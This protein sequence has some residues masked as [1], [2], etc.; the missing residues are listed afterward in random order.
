VLHPG[1]ARV[2]PL[3]G[4]SLAPRASVLGPSGSARG[5]VEPPTPTNPL[6]AARARPARRRRCLPAPS[7][8]TALLHAWY[9][10]HAS[11]RA[12][13]LAL[14]SA[15]AGFPLICHTPPVAVQLPVATATCR[16]DVDTQRAVTMA[17]IAPVPL[18]GPRLPLRV[19]A[20][21]PWTGVRV[22]AAAAAGSTPVHGP[23]P[24]WRTAP[25]SSPPCCQHS[26]ES[27]PP[28]Y[29]AGWVPERVCNWFLCRFWR[30]QLWGR[31]WNGWVPRPPVPLYVGGYVLLVWRC[32]QFLLLTSTCVQQIADS[33][34]CVLLSLSL[35]SIFVPAC[36]RVTL[37][38]SLY[39][40]CLLL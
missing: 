17:F 33:V 38:P 19:T 20:S 15:D 22:R 32:F 39:G 25:S 35:S 13:C 29:E 21:R 7:D 40:S 37:S 16:D 10:P 3:P 2:T 23:P 26:S 11:R 34:V 12:S 9:A 27:E 4:P 30:F 1:L 24:S 6:R 28:N 14:S 8:P 18:L 5:D 36:R 31:S